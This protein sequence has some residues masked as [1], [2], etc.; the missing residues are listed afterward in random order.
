MGHIL[1]V[2]SNTNNKWI[3]FRLTNIDM[4]IIRVGVGFTNIDTIHVLT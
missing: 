4:F 3:G 1:I 2:L